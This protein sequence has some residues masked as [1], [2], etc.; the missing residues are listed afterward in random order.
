MWDYDFYLFLLK[1]GLHEGSAKKQDDLNYKNYQILFKEYGLPDKLKDLVSDDSKMES[2]LNM[3]ASEEYTCV[4]KNQNALKLY[5]YYVNNKWFDDWQRHEL[6]NIGTFEH[7]IPK[8][9]SND[10]LN[11]SYVVYKK[12]ISTSIK[13]PGLRRFLEAEYKKHIIDA[14]RRILDSTTQ[15]R[16]YPL[17]PVILRKEKPEEN[18]FETD[19]SI[20]RRIAHLER[21]NN[22]NF[23]ESRILEIL[24]DRTH[25]HPVLG[26][27]HH[28]GCPKYA[29]DAIDNPFRF[30]N[31]STPYIEI[32]YCNTTRTDVE[33]YK[34]LMANCLAH[35]YFHFLHD[36]YAQNQ[37]QYKSFTRDAVIEGLADFF[38]V[39]YNNYRAHN[40]N[41]NSDYDFTDSLMKLSEQ[42]YNHWDDMYG[43]SWPY[44]YAIDVF[45]TNGK[46][47]SYML[48]SD[49]AVLLKFNNVLHTSKNSMDEAYNKLT[50]TN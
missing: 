16:S 44:A 14:A 30:E 4:V 25:K 21:K 15:F 1:Q 6:R 33:D 11:T 42:K 17:I 23:S 49:D 22:G 36:L 19:E 40:S 31:G 35:E 32:F 10:E 41:S 28:E 50:D 39:Y 24:K 47:Y 12:N 43:S 8:Q 38:S 45:N 48:V 7:C 20:A 46:Q 3:L 26:L 9:I 37:F 13:I 18:Y 34:A 5:Y 29:L 27:Y 2:A